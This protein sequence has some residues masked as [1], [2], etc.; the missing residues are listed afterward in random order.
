MGSGGW[1]WRGKRGE[2]LLLFFFFRAPTHMRNQMGDTPP[3]LAR[4]ALRLA[5]EIHA[6]NVVLLEEVLG[7]VSRDG[8]VTPVVKL[9]RAFGFGWRS[10]GDIGEQNVCCGYGV[11]V[12]R[13]GGRGQE[14]RSDGTVRMRPFICASAFFSIQ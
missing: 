2:M 4:L 10:Q 7:A 9:K 11:E 12:C 5:H 13:M 8:A 6:L 3:Y 1:G 14:K